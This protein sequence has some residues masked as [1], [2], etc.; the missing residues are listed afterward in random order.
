[1]TSAAPDRLE[2]AT[3]ALAGFVA[4]RV[5]PVD[6]DALAANAFVALVEA[7]PTLVRVEDVAARLARSPRTL[8]ASRSGSSGCRRPPSSAGAGCRRPP[9]ASAPTPAR[10]W[11]GSPP[12]SATP[13]TAT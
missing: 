2:R 4:D 7:D 6:E 12:T 11:P 9:N 10:T 1:M 8:H 3:A 13:T 5:G